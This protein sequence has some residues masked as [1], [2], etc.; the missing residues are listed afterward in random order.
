MAK[1]ICG[2]NETDVTTF[3]G[4]TIS[5]ARNGLRQSLNNSDDMKVLLN[6]NEI[7]DMQSVIRTDDE[8]EWVKPGGTKGR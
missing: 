8:I 2:C 3:D 5:D 6:S 4:R 7:S 1:F